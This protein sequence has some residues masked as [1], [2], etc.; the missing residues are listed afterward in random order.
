MKGKVQIDREIT[1]FIETLGELRRREDVRKSSAYDTIGCLLEVIDRLKIQLKRDTFFSFVEQRL[2]IKL[3]KY[4][5]DYILGYAGENVLSKCAS[6]TR[7]SL[8]GY[9]KLAY[10]GKDL[11]L[12]TG[13]TLR[14]ITVPKLDTYIYEGIVL[15]SEL[16]C[17]TM[18][19]LYENNWRYSI[20]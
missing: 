18:N 9:I 20:R 1:S 8:I 7:E 3:E 19:R 16:L 6:V 13:K 5:K 11:I 17:D 2:D 15:P 14:I 4:E 12:Y 10:S